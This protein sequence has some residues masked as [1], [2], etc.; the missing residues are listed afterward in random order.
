MRRR[1]AVSS[2][3]APRVGRLRGPACPGEPAGHDAPW[4]LFPARSRMHGPEYL[5]RDVIRWIYLVDRC[6]RSKIRNL[7]AL[8]ACT[9][10]ARLRDDVNFPVVRRDACRR[11]ATGGSIHGA[12]RSRAARRATSTR[13]FVGRHSKRGGGVARRSGIGA[14]SIRGSARSRRARGA[15]TPP[16]RGLGHVLPLQPRGICRMP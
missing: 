6:P 8:V 4:R 7:S 12:R 9:W 1:S 15:A 10:A 5:Q 2:F 13:W 14:G 3:A 16:G 11:A